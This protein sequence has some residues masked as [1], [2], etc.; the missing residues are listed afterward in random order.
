MKQ[1]SNATKGSL[2]LNEELSRRLFQILSTELQPKL[3]LKEEA[4]QWESLK[5]WRSYQHWKLVNSF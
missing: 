5:G 1:S 4:V 2:Q 3:A